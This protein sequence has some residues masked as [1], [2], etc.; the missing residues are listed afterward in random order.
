MEGKV[1]VASDVEQDGGE[2]GEADHRDPTEQRT[3]KA[4][5]EEDRAEIE[6]QRL[7][8]EQQRLKAEDSERRQVHLQAEQIKQLR[9]LMADTMDSLDR[10]KKL[11]PAP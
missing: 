9:S 5:F 8:I 4:T 10:L 2:A 11:R 3:R 1:S 7:N 6:Q